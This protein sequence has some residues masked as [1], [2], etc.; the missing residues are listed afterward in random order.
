MKRLW[1]IVF[2]FFFAACALIDDDLSVC[3]EELV[4]DYQLQLHTELSMQL[5]TELMTETEL[6]VRQALE[7]WLEPIFTE[8]AK[9]VDLRFFSSETDE[10]RHH[11]YEIINDKRTSYTLQL[12]K[13]NYMHLGVANIADNDQVRL[14]GEKHSES[15]KLSLIDGLNVPS[16]STG[17][18]TARQHMEIG[19]SSANFAVR[20]YMANSAV[21]LVLDTTICDSLVSISGTVIGSAISF[22]VR[23]SIYTYDHS[24]AI[25]LNELP[26]ERK[27]DDGIKKMRRAEEIT[28]TYACM[29]V[30]TFPTED[31]KSW[32]MIVHVMLQGNRR[33]TTTLTIDEPLAAGTLRIIRVHVDAQG[34]IQPDD[35]QKEVAAS[36]ELDWNNGTE[37]EIEF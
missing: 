17:V 22:S 10:L 6:P 8:T 19:D 25:I 34:G 12:P 37:I 21:A 13:E 31:D 18:F 33:T 1:V 27:M 15:L 9:D 5:Q 24:R 32:S 30:S 29:V 14:Q 26:I 3:G 20:L 36:V 4:I 16:L 23:D 7:K 35:G 28:D 11:I 2:P